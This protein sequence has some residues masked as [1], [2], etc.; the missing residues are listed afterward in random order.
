MI[1]VESFPQPASARGFA[2]AS[3]ALR[4]PVLKMTCKRGPVMAR[5]SS[6]RSHPACCA[7]PSW[8]ASAK[9][10]RTDEGARYTQRCRLGDGALAPCPPFHSRSH[11]M[12]GTPSDRAFARADDFAHP[13]AARDSTMWTC[14]LPSSK[15]WRSP[16][17]VSAGQPV[18]AFRMIGASL[19]KPS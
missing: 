1:R 8:I 9:R 12:V 4:R 16:N 6:R 11:R 7:A 18:N 3:P 2:E 13:T 5:S 17:P 14:R 15:K 10:A 19:R